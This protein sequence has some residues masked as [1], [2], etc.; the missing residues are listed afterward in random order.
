VKVTFIRIGAPL[1]CDAGPQEGDTRID[2][3]VKLYLSPEEHARYAGPESLQISL[4][5]DTNGCLPAGTRAP[6][7]GG[8]S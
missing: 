1:Y 2:L 3:T 5:D 8:L 4:N 7:A 6:D